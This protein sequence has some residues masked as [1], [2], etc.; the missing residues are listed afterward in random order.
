MHQEIGS[1]SQVRPIGF[2]RNQIVL[3]GSPAQVAG[4]IR[5]V[6][7]MDTSAGASPSRQLVTVALVNLRNA[8]GTNSR[9]KWMSAATLSSRQQ[10]LAPR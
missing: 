2:V 8:Y 1:V 9:G 7:V 6:A 4:V 5:V 3:G 10:M